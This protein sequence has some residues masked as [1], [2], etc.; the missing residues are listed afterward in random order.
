MTEYFGL[1]IYTVTIRP[2]H[3]FRG[4]STLNHCSDAWPA[5]SSARDHANP[6]GS[7]KMLLFS[8]LQTSV[9]ARRA[10]AMLILT[11]YWL[12]LLTE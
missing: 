10:H 7:C 2:N 5:P 1:S 8:Y 9:L 12:D 3:G 6:L 11:L 4:S